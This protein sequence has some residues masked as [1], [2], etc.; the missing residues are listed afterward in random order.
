MAQLENIDLFLSSKRKLAVLYKDFFENTQIN[1]IKEPDG[2]TSNYWLNSILLSSLAQRDEFLEYTNSCGILTRPSWRLI[3]QQKMYNHCQT[4][5]LENSISISERLVNL[6][7]S[8]S[9]TY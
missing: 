8:Y 2:A 9:R 3:S 5:D 1:F 6:P 7:S 4:L